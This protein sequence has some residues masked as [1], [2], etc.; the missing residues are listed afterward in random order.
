VWG[1]GIPRSELRHGVRWV[2][3]GLTA[4]SLL[5]CVTT[6]ALWT[7]SHWV[8][9]YIPF[10]GMETDGHSTAA[11]SYAL[12][13]SRGGVEFCGYRSGYTSVDPVAPQ[14]FSASSTPL[15]WV[16]TG[17]GPTAV[18]FGIPPKAWCL[19]GFTFYYSGNR[20]GPS[21]TFTSSYLGQWYVQCPYWALLTVT[22]FLP[23]VRG[24][25]WLR[26]RRRGLGVCPKC[27]Y[28][29]RASPERCPECGRVR[30]RDE[31]TRQ[32]TR[33]PPRGRPRVQA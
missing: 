31:L 14:T 21:A 2:I 6:A 4:I 28:D 32:N 18:P 26:R 27:G 13:W 22:A 30:R 10:D 7:R 16:H 8:S 23:L 29:L 12:A 3:Q 1:V 11:W 9:D 5:L 15:H 19:A 20:A 24:W 25:R 33:G 17:A